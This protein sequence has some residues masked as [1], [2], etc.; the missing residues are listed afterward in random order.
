MKDQKMEIELGSALSGAIIIILLALPF[1]MLNSSKRKREK[2]FL[3]SLSEIAAQN[4]CQI[5]Q[6]EL[7]GSFAIGIDESKNHV[8]F[9]RQAKDKQFAQSVDLGEVQSSKVIKTSR[10]LKNNGEYQEVLDRLELGFV[11]LDE[12]KSETKL[13]FFNTDVNVQLYGELQ[14]IEKWSQLINDRL[15][16]KK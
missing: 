15:E 12:K 6:H 9:Y 10:T 4:N 11:P 8:F 13:E 16:Q 7:F 1:V 5:D 3:Q 14:S 2:K